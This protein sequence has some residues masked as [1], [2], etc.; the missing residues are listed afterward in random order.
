MNLLL[1][2]SGGRE[3]ALAW[4]L[5]QSEQ[6]K[7][8][9]VAPGNPGI[10]LE[11]KVVCTGVS[12][13]DFVGIKKL[14]VEKRI[15]LVVVGPDQAL[16]DGLVDELLIDGV[17]VFGPSRAAAQLEWSK[18]FAKQLMA[19]HGIP[20]AKFEAF[21][22][23]PAA[24]EFLREVE[25]KDGW[26]IKADGLA[27]GKGVVVCESREQ[28]LRTAREFLESGLMGAAGAKIVV[29]ERLLGREASA[30]SL[31]D[32]E[33]AVSLGFACD[34][35]RIFDGDQGPNTGGM[36]AFSPADWL[37]AGTHERVQSE[38]VQPL[39]AAM[40]ARGTPFR[41]VLFTGL[42]I[43]SEGPKVIEFNARF[44]DPETQS[45]M[46][47]IDEDLL[48]WLQ[49]SASGSL[50]SLP[51]SGPRLKSLHS[52]HVVLAAAGYPGGGGV[53]VRKGDEITV[54]TEFFPGE[55]QGERLA[56]LFFAGVAREGHPPRLLTAGGRV[57]GITAL[58]PSREEARAKAY[59]LI[60]AVKFAGSQRRNDVGK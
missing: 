20:T 25:W 17:N 44:G 53:E 51:S 10:A 34:Y 13:A 18:A 14:C 1:I 23:L 5:A 50:A 45:L 47:L 11:G 39:L 3:H 42:M 56:K 57:L 15:G 49:A 24:E 43:T 60:D 27:L 29:E 46:P 40:R 30:F 31:C 12:A 54:P 36:G 26:V 35:K 52:V 28:A 6:V 59:S 55:G 33:R 22:A 9:F 37:P 16:A 48:P 41:G 32:G 58:A 8:L 19:E 7:E 2:G 38:I 21:C 4:K